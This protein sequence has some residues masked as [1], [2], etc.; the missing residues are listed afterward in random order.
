LAGE[1]TLNACP[2][3]QCV[4]QV[5]AKSFDGVN[6]VENFATFSFRPRARSCESNTEPGPLSSWGFLQP[7]AVSVNH[8]GR[9]NRHVQHD[10]PPV[11]IR[12]PARQISV[13]ELPDN[14]LA[15][16]YAVSLCEKVELPGIESM[17]PCI[18][19]N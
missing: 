8:L 19:V 14:F 10:G 15:L 6:L 5:I 17:R 18:A 13:A 9:L 4:P 12:R 7:P 16:H 2:Q 11:V 1:H 3:L